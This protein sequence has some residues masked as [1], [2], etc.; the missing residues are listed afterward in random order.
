MS[1]QNFPI[2]LS[3]IIQ[4]KTIIHILVIFIN[5]K[6]N[7]DVLKLSHPERQLLFPNIKTQPGC[8]LHSFQSL[9][10]YQNQRT[11]KKI[12]IASWQKYLL[13]RR[14]KYLNYDYKILVLQC[15]KFKHILENLQLSEWVK[16]V[17]QRTCC[18]Q[19]ELAISEWSMYSIYS[20]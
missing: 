9:F 15:H 12:W 10:L 13:I 20:A 14:V 19:V 8:F 1:K 16:Q 3:N 11:R 6:K 4:S 2:S 7:D 17:R 18:W 5:I